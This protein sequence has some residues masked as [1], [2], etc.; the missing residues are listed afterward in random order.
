MYLVDTNVISEARKRSKAN[1]GVQDFF[2]L[3]T[4]E[5]APGFVSVVTVGELRRGV[6]LI[7]HRGDTRQ[8]AQLEKWLEKLLVKYQDFILDFDKNIAQLWGRLRV[9]HP[10]NALDKQIAATALIHDLT[11][12][13]RNHKD[14][15]KTGVRTLNPF[16]E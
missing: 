16:R 8:A 9:P 12:V 13:T 3:V 7:R 15:T 11:V 10:E 14:F 6:E 2:K 1:K 5:R 4:S